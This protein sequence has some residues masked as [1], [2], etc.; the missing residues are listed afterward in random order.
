MDEK[1]IPFMVISLFINVLVLG[2]VIYTL[3]LNKK[4][5]NLCD[6]R[7]SGEEIGADMERSA[8]E[9]AAALREELNRSARQNREELNN[10]LKNLQDVLVNNYAHFNTLEQSQ[11][12]QIRGALDM[13]IRALSSET[14]QEF[15]Q[16]NES[17]QKQL[18]SLRNTLDQKLRELQRDNNQKLEQMRVVV[19]EKLHATLEQRLGESFKMVSERL[20]AVYKGLGEMRNL[21][22]GVGDLKKVLTNIKTRGT[23]GEIQLGN[24]LADILTPEQFQANVDVKNN[25][26]RVE[27]AV[28]LP[29]PDA[30]EKG[31]WLPIDAKFPMEDYHRLLEAYD[32]SDPVLIEI[33]GK[34]LEACVKQQ[35]KSISEKYVAPPATTEFAIMFLPTESL[36][37]EVLRRPGLFEK[38]RR[39]HRITIAGPTTLAAIVT[40]LSMGFKT[41][42][43]Q[44]RSGEVWQVLSA[45]KAEFLKF[46]AVLEKTRKKLQEASN[47]IEE[48]SRRSRVMERRLKNITTAPLDSEGENVL[49]NPETDN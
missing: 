25:S 13:R 10:T 37:A 42:A 48:T 20:E 23:W 36:Y 28:L 11:L 1:F 15:K 47:S 24:I 30:D 34:A 9:N 14:V 7:F 44:K 26:Q 33:S 45:V 12:E 16:M 35:A 40:S 46:G 32:K 49:E 19:D 39:E 31:V 41:L 21:A 29:G 2:L 43:L 5:A 17:L 38:I 6:S 27:Y 8:R 18:E 3:K 22:A 4:R